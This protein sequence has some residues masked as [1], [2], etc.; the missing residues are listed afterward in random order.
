MFADFGAFPILHLHNEKMIPAIQK[1]Y[2]DN[3]LPL[4]TTFTKQHKESTLNDIDTV[5][6]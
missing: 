2:L 1:P 3:T 5:D 4:L 6:R